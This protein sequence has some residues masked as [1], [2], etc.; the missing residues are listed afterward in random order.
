MEIKKTPYRIKLEQRD[1][2]IAQEY[3]LMQSR[4][5]KHIGEKLAEKYGYAQK[6]A[7]YAAIKRYYK[8]LSNRPSKLW[9]T[10]CYG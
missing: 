7:V 8:Q 3:F 4:K 9:H 10:S 5:E 6:N 2:E 1:A